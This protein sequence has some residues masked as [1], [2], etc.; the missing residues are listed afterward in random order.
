MEAAARTRLT[1]RLREVV[2]DRYTLADPYEIRLYQY[3]SRPE[4]A[5]PDLVVIPASAAEVAA[6]VKIC[7][8]EGC[9]L[10]SRAGA[11]GLAGGTVPV[12][13]GVV[14]AFSRMD[15]ILELD[16]ENLRA[17]VEPG[18]VNLAL[19]NATRP[20][21]YYYVPD[22]SSQGASTIGGNVATNAG[23]PHTLLYG[24]TVNHVTGLELALPSGELV[25]VGGGLDL[26][27]DV[28]GDRPGE[29][30]PDFGI[31]LGVEDRTG[32]QGPVVP[33]MPAGV[34]QE[35]VQR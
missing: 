31:V 11:T 30:L 6:V 35:P 32:G 2:G 15:R 13:G 14:L 3:D 33:A 21:G 22:P 18:L 8:E 17:V 24:V 12:F 20:R 10:V 25:Q 23:G 4:T 26:G 7:A 19:S 1:D 9:P 28:P 5:L 27:H 29:P 34:P 16:Y